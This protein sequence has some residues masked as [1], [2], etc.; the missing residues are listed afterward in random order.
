MVFY[1]IVVSFAWLTWNDELPEIVHA[2]YPNGC[3]IVNT[4]IEPCTCGGEAD[5]VQSYQEGGRD[6]IESRDVVCPNYPENCTIPN[7]L[8]KVPNNN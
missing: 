7:V 8:V 5:E 4:E 6:A 1:L 2:Q 3:F